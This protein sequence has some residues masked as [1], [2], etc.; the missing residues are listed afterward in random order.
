MGAQRRGKVAVVGGLWPYLRPCIAGEGR[1]KKLRQP[2]RYPT[3]Q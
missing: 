2:L 3:K 1:R